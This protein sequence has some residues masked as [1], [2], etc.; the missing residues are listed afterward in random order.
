[1]PQ[2][3]PLE[4][5]SPEVKVLGICACVWAANS[6]ARVVTPM[7]FSSPVGGIG[8]GVSTEMSRVF[9]RGIHSAIHDIGQC[10]LVKK[11]GMT[12]C[13]G[14]VADVRYSLVTRRISDIDHDSGLGEEFLKC[15]C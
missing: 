8:E 11:D 9:A 3:V 15:H 5:D 12:S 1:M 4:P 6:G 13:S 14:R 7:T 10:S 2:V